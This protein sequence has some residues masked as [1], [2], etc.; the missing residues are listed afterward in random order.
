M[1]SKNVLRY[2]G[3]EIYP[4][5]LIEYKLEYCLKNGFGMRFG[6]KLENCNNSCNHHYNS[7]NFTENTRKQKKQGKTK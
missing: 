6:K 4:T 1:C 7:C 5:D 3:F 2:K